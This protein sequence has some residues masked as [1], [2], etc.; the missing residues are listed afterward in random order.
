M[1]KGISNSVKDLQKEWSS[2]FARR[3]LSKVLPILVILF[4]IYIVLDSYLVFNVNVRL[5]AF[6]S[7]VAVALFFYLFAYRKN[8]KAY[9]EDQAIDDLENHLQQGQ[10]LRTAWQE[11][12]KGVENEFALALSQSATQALKGVKSKEIVPWDTIKLLTALA[13]LMTTTFLAI[14]FMSADYVKSFQRILLPTSDI[15]FTQIKEVTYKESYKEQEPFQIDVKLAGRE[16]EKVTLRYRLVNQEEWSTLD[17]EVIEDQEQSFT[18]TFPKLSESISF[19]ILAAD[20]STKV[21]EAHLLRATRLNGVEV[22]VQAPSYTGADLRVQKNLNIQALAGSEISWKLS[23]DRN[24]LQTAQLVFSR[25]QTLDLV[26][27]DDF[28]LAKGKFPV[29][30]QDYTLN[31]V[32]EDGLAMKEEKYYLN[33]YGD[34]KVKVKLRYPKDEQKVRAMEDLTTQI[35]AKDDFGVKSVGLTIYI[36]NEE[37]KDLLGKSFDSHNEVQ[38]SEVQKLLLENFELGIKTNLSVEAYAY[39]WFHEERSVSTRHFLT[40]VPYKTRAKLKVNE[41]QKKKKEEGRNLDE[42]KKAM[43]KISQLIKKEKTLYK[44]SAA[45]FKDLKK[46]DFA[47]LVD[48]QREVAYDLEELVNLIKASNQGLKQDLDNKENSGG[49]I[50]SAV[51]LPVLDEKNKDEDS[52]IKEFLGKQLEALTAIEEA[53]EKAEAAAKLLESKDVKAQA[54]QNRVLTALIQLRENMVKELLLD[55]NPPEDAEPDEDESEE[56]KLSSEAIL[57]LL[58]EIIA[59]QEFITKALEKRVN[60]Q[61]RSS[62]EILKKR[63]VEVIALAREFTEHLPNFL[64]YHKRLMDRFEAIQE[65]LSTTAKALNGQKIKGAHKSSAASLLNS[66]ELFLIIKS[67]NKGTMASTIRRLKALAESESANF[68]RMQ[69]WRDADRR[70]SERKLRFLDDMIHAFYMSRLP[71]LMQI[72][73]A[74]KQAE[75]DNAV[76]LMDDKSQDA[77][78]YYE[79]QEEKLGK[80]IDRRL[81]RDLKYLAED[82]EK[83]HAQFIQSRLDQLAKAEQKVKE[84]QDEMKKSQESKKSQKQKKEEKQDF[85]KKLEEVEK[86]ARDLSKKLLGK[87]DKASMQDRKDSVKDFK[88]A[89]KELDK[90]SKNMREGIQRRLNNAKQENKIAKIKDDGDQQ[91]RQKEQGQVK[92]FINELEALKNLLEREQK[93]EPDK[94]PGK[95]QGSGQDENADYQMDSDGGEKSSNKLTEIAKYLEEVKKALEATNTDQAKTEALRKGLNE[96][97]KSLGDLKDEAEELDLD[98]LKKELAAEEAKLD[99]LEKSLSGLKSS[100]AKKAG[101]G[102]ESKDQQGSGSKDGQETEAGTQAEF[103]AEGKQS[104]AKLSKDSQE[105]AK[106]LAEISNKI[107]EELKGTGQEEGS[108]SGESK[109]GQ[110]PKE[111]AGAGAGEGEEKESKEGSG[112]GQDGKSGEGS[113]YSKERKKQEKSDRAGQGNRDGGRSNSVLKLIEDLKDFEDDEINEVTGA[114]IS[115]LKDG[116]KPSEELLAQLRARLKELIKKMIDDNIKTV[117]DKPVS[118]AYEE[119]VERY[120]KR[121][122]DDLGED[123]E[124]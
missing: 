52:Q 17:L 42:L 73:A 112:Q 85:K 79:K 37:G 7:L 53:Y 107:K 34:K 116:Q 87:D 86:R 81:S 29:G 111:G 39:D 83:I 55:D 60:K 104:L 89:L 59:E 122:S 32:N 97:K 20:A 100:E 92:S 5:T 22:S 75:L 24:D 84:L 65:G 71:N 31:V 13:V 88:K 78:S 35:I 121:L 3:A 70:V 8:K 56:Q 90:K 113:G 93:E 21:Y 30:G 1:K 9:K 51:Y 2:F 12:Q 48:E 57:Q 105:L 45:A 99:A 28:W 95:S 69:N 106:A 49:I 63:Q 120:F 108:G 103:S 110:D 80:K 98:G 115:E 102:E 117:D 94:L 40:V 119:L 14:V 33:M 19:Q 41:A 46:A 101:S 26:Q 15:T 11:E 36:S 18:Y 124:L 25:G 58:A 62:L 27:Q 74:L 43:I 68:A 66:E 91:A 6:L 38:V 50:E 10:L 76:D 61:D 114:L 54:E 96:L 47:Q 77:E 109:D 67:I 23:F 44:K 123:D 118:P 16:T 4:L 82:L 64:H 72:K